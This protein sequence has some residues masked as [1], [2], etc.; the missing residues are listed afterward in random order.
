MGMDRRNQAVVARE[1]ARRLEL[2]GGIVDTRR[3][4]YGDIFAGEYGETLTPISPQLFYPTQLWQALP[5][6]ERRLLLACAAGRNN[7]K[8][9]LIGRSAARVAGMWVVALTEEKV[10]VTMPGAKVGPSVRKNPGYKAYHFNL[11]ERETYDADGYRATRM[12]R[13]AIDI[14]RL[15]GFAEGLIACDWLLRVGGD[16]A[17]IEREIR[18]MGRFKGAGT[19]RRCLRHATAL[20][21]SP[22]ESLARALLIEAGLDPR[23]QWRVGRY[24][25]DLALD[26]WLLIEIDGDG[27][28]GSDTAETIK[29]ENDR[30]KRIENQGYRIMRYRPVELLNNP[31]TFVEEVRAALS[32]RSTPPGSADPRPLPR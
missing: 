6:H 26:G 10:E 8:T 22:F 20:S 23:P 28:Y 31:A 17:D 13:T 5:G 32:K 12:I 15:H 29:R 4:T 2:Y 16:K 24:R 11:H 1:R 3:L 9:V 14:A 25:A 7:T 18:R 27:K 19:V 30:K 21:E